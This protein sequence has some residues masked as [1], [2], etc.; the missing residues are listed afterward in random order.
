MQ[1][2]LLL[3]GALGS[4]DHFFAL[5]E[6]L[7]AV[8]EVYSFNF[9]GHG[10]SEM[11]DFFS[12]ANFAAEVRVFLDQNKIEK[13]SI[14]GYSMGGYVGLYFAKNFPERVEKVVTLATKWSWTI[15]GAEQEVK[16]LNP[17]I[18]KQKVPKYAN[19]LEQLHGN[20]W[21][22]VIE[23]TAKMMLQLGANPM[24]QNEDFAQMTTP[25]LLMVGDKDVMVSIE[26]TTKVYRLLPNAQLMVVPNTQH[27][28]DRV[29]TEELAHQII[30]FHHI[31]ILKNNQSDQL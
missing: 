21:E 9:K 25:I 6:K 29:N 2:L 4:Q 18:I 12:I 24:F 27:P 14:F 19:S 1:K 10:A 26:E 31:E 30:F 8:F 28:I 15:T 16:R 20:S 3:H 5:K 17:T 11:P 13:T 23:K 22:L 7:S